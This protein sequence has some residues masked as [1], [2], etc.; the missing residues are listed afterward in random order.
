MILFGFGGIIVVAGSFRAYWVHE[1]LFGTYDVTWEGFNL[2]VW[3]AVETN[4]GVICGCIPAL[5]PL[6]FRTRSPGSTRSYALGSVG[7][8]NSHASGDM[9]LD[10]HALTTIDSEPS[11]APPYEARPGTARRSFDLE[12]SKP[13]SGWEP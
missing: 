12:K 11:V 6:L 3:T 13:V 1:V 10:S 2:W 4:V 8:Q 5:K 7:K 9:E